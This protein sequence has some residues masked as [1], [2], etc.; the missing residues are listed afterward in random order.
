[1]YQN[2][3][4]RFDKVLIVIKL[5]VLCATFY[6]EKVSIYCVLYIATTVSIL[7]ATE[8]PATFV[9]L[10]RLFT[11]SSRSAEALWNCA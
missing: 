5:Y 3:P 1:M 8:L 6:K 9:C 10:K 2:P 11:A 7:P 4:A